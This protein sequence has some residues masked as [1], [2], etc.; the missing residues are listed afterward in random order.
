MSTPP[1]AALAARLDE[2]LD[3][4]IADGRIVGA[5]VA[6]ALDGRVAYRR[7][8]GLADRATGAPLRPD[9]IFR[10]SSVTKCIVSLAALA[11]ADQGRLALDA[12]ITR[13]LP[14]FRPRLANGRE[15][16]ISARQLLT[17]TAGLFYPDNPDHGAAYRERGV[18]SGLDGLFTDM[19]EAMRR[20][21][22]APLAAEPGQ[23]W[24]YSL[25]IDVLG[26][27]IEGVTGRPLAQAVHQLVLAP[28]GM[29]DSG[30]AV[31]DG[32]RLATPYVDA[33]PHPLPMPAHHRATMEGGGGF[34]F[35][36]GRIHAA[37]AYPSGGSGMV[38]TADD[39]LRAL[40]AIRTGH[41][42]VLS[43]AGAARARR[44]RASRWSRRIPTSSA[45][46]AGAGAWSARCW[47]TR[48]PPPRRSRRAR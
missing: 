45:C 30:F 37:G 27:V 13:W 22:D 40:E 36:P 39:V 2:V 33:L 48:L 31:A 38:G 11:L 15:P 21:A 46:P 4:T 19:A 9:A 20:I 32:T 18:S 23:R 28:L 42:G 5:V 26:A 41:P 14:A 25:A 43:V 10:L 3:R 35:A 47:S 8:A 7:A 6:V 24:I 1:N 29:A 16:A 44:A 12:P 34:D 17:H